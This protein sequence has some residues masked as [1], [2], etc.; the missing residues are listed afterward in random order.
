M[1]NAYAPISHESMIDRLGDYLKTQLPEA[2]DI[3]IENVKRIA[4][5]WSHETWLLDAEWV[6]DGAKHTRPLCVRRDP[7]NALLRDTSD[8]KVQFQVLKCLEATKVPTPAPYWYEED[9]DILGAPFI[10][11]EKVEGVCPSAYSSDGRKFY[12]AAADRGVLP[13]EF[14][15]TLADLHTLDWRGAGLDFLGVPA[16]TRDFALSEI[17]KWQKLIEDSEL[18]I[19]PILV[20]LM[21]WLEENVPSDTGRLS[22]V[23]GGYRTG[24]LL[25]QDDKIS[26]VLDWELQVIGDPLYDVAYVLSDL[27]RSGTELLSNLVDRDLFFERYEAATGIQIDE[28]ACRYYQAL[29]VLRTAAFWMSA[30]GL[31]AS[32]ASDDLRLAR[33]AWSITTV[34]DRAAQALN[35]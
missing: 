27:N 33:A 35:Y 22:L 29:Y 10:V 28:G 25:I 13:L 16:D 19:S 26:A 5:G 4:V 34:L 9:L 11:M 8:L 14:I 15:D 21:C 31:Y 30:A 1:S 20:D 12:Q 6:A 2:R 3:R 23:H 7:G 17:S 18:P 24:N 32:G